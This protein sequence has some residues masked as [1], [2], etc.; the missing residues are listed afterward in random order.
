MAVDVELCRVP[1]HVVMTAIPYRRAVW[2]QVVII[3]GVVVAVAV[4][5][6]SI[7]PVVAKMLV[8]IQCPMDWFLVIIILLAPLDTANSNN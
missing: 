8:V 3:G 2:V 7:M 1:N 6:V 5:V 4:P